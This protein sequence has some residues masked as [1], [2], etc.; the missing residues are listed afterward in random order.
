MIQS[1]KNYCD[2]T[3]KLIRESVDKFV[4]HVNIHMPNFSS[5][6]SGTKTTAPNT[7]AKNRIYQS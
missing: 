2:D 1:L 4:A 3:F 7:S 5:R 6:K